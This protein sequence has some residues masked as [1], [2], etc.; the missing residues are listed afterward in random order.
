MGR[1]LSISAEQLRALYVAATAIPSIARTKFKF[2]VLV[3]LEHRHGRTAV[4]D[5]DI[6]RAIDYVMR[7]APAPAPALLRDV[8]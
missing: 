8:A 2:D 3:E 1:Y 7:T 4:S 6:S 5:V